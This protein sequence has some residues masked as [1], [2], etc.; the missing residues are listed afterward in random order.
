MLPNNRLVGRAICSTLAWDDSPLLDP[1]TRLSDPLFLDGALN[2]GF[3]MAPAQ[4]EPFVHGTA[5]FWLICVHLMKTRICTD[6][7][8]SMKPIARRVHLSSHKLISNL[9]LYFIFSFTM[10]STPYYSSLSPPSWSAFI[11]NTIHLAITVPTARS[12]PD[13]ISPCQQDLALDLQ[14]VDDRYADRFRQSPV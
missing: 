7:E 12:L 6:G 2:F 4:S 3:H 8:S 13:R 5:H 9:S 14:I 1:D 10:F 11:H